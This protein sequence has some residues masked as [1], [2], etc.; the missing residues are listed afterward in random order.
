MVFATSCGVKLTGLDATR[1][2]QMPGV[3]NFVVAKDVAG[4]NA[5][6]PGKIFYEIGD[7]I[8]YVG[9]PLG[10][11]V[12]DTWAQARLAA[13]I[14]SQSFTATSRESVICPKS[15]VQLG[16][17]ASPEQ[18]TLAHMNPKM[19][20]LPR[21]MKFATAGIHTVDADRVEADQKVSGEFKT[22]GQSHFYLETQ[23]VV[24]IPVGGDCYEVYASSQAVDTVQKAI[25]VALGVPLSK[26][27]VHNSPIGGAFG[28]KADQQNMFSAAVAVAAAKLRRPVRLQN[29]RSDDMQMSGSRH[30]ISFEYEATFDQ[31]GKLGSLSVKATTDS[32]WSGS[33][34]GLA[35]AAT[36]DNNYKWAKY[37]MI[38]VDAHTSKPASQTMRAP[39]S[40]QSALAG[41]VILEHLA[42][43]LGKDLDEMMKIN[44]YKEGDR[45]VQQDT[46]GSETCN[47]TLPRLWAQLQD[48]SEYFERKAS[49]RT[50]NE[51]NKWTKKG[52]AISTSRWTLEGL[53]PSAFTMT[54]HISVCR[55][56]TIIVCTGGCD[57][58][59]G[60]NTK[61]ALA[62]A[63]CLGIP[64]SSVSIGDG[65][66]NTCPNNFITAASVT[67]ESCV[68]ATMDACGQIRTL[69]KPY[70]EKGMPWM[71]AVNSAITDGVNLVGNGRNRTHQ[72]NHANPAVNK[73]PYIVYGGCVTE[74]L[75]DVLTGEVR[76]ERVD[77]LMDLGRQL[78][79]AIDIGQLQ[80]GF[81]MALGYMFTEG[82]KRAASGE[83][84]TLG[85]WEYKIPTAYDIPVE[86]NV[87]ILKG[88][89]NPNGVKSSKAVAEPVMHLV[90]SPYLAVKNAIYAARKDVGLGENWFMLDV[91]CSPEVVRSAI[92]VST[93]HMI[94][95]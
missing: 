79:A 29:E 24:V 46:I 69:L 71:A 41:D 66:T 22:G 73:H 4:S 1:A 44:F 21:N 33:G 57:M 15:A 10:V 62:A 68:A 59:Q 55:D 51:Q 48:E 91:P 45:T 58:G 93:E 94:I 30:P 28:G 43:T 35:A 60:L 18:A 39:A 70:T 3:R 86:F 32:G 27:L 95:P 90:T 83:I 25:G 40:M 12:A 54:A 64:L 6:P 72:W 34:F 5:C 65:D 20:G 26:V 14:V 63:Q 8:A 81:V 49:V 52:L 87:S 75:L 82:E 16:R 17:M 80:G 78:D 9:A 85:T 61:V 53:P 92:G 76:L 31:T 88:S 19:M 37:S 74:V 84:M 47:F 23:S 36:C 7:D 56:G 2:L 42:K 77:I 50:Y 13:K 11:I 67:S 89:P 38:G